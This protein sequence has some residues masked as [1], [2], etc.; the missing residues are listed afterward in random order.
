MKNFLIVTT[1]A[2]IVRDYLLHS[3]F[4]PIANLIL[5]GV[6]Q[7]PIAPYKKREAKISAFAF[8]IKTL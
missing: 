4:V 8:Q 5:N 1:L 3:L 2:A 7:N 6:L